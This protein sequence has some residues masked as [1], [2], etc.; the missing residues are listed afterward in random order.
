VKNEVKIQK[1]EKNYFSNFLNFSKIIFSLVCYK[2]SH[3][4]LAKAGIIGMG[5][6]GV[7][8]SDFFNQ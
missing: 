6:R 2:K 3:F 1:F 5:A 8:F 4:S 7:T